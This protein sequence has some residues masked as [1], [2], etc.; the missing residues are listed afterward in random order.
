MGWLLFEVHDIENRV[1]MK[2]YMKAKPILIRVVLSE[3]EKQH[4]GK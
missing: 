3:G 2:V 1:D 4:N